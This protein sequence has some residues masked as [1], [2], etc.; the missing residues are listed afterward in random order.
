MSTQIR[1][2]NVRAQTGLKK[3]SNN[4]VSVKNV[5]TKMTQEKTTSVARRDPTLGKNSSQ[6]FTDIKLGIKINIKNN[7]S[8][9]KPTV[10]IR[11]LSAFAQTNNA[12]FRR[13]F[14]TNDDDVEVAD[15][16]KSK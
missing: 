14:S 16:D 3:A 1:S 13:S 7:A 9:F 2:S 8:A 10:Q 15:L 12:I 4:K 5:Q 11:T 6:L